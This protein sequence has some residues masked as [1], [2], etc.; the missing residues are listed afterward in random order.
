MLLLAVVDTL[1]LCFSILTFSL[2]HLSDMYAEYYWMLMVP[3][4]LP[5]AQV[6]TLTMSMYFR[7]MQL[8]T[9]LLDMLDSQCLHDSVSHRGEILL[10]GASSLSTSKQVIM[11]DH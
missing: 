2:P 3:Y 4:T 8:S 6:M 11:T 1:F 7:K 9:L 10:G 5:L